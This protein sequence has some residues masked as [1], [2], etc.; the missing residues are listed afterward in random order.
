MKIY[1]EFLIFLI[2]VFSFFIWLIWKSLSQKKLLKKYNPKDD[3]GR[4]GETL[5]KEKR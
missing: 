4:K 1:I 2:L 5:W 3:L